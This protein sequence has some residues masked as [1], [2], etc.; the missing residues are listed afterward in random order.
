MA[1]L[2]GLSLLA[3][4]AG[5]A[6]PA[7]KVE[8]GL[9]V[10]VGETVEI[11][12]SSG[13]CWFPTINQFPTGEIIV[14]ISMGPDWGSPEGDITGYCLS[15]DGGH[16]WSP[17]Y[18]MSAT[19]LSAASQNPQKDGAIWDIGGPVEAHPE[20]QSQE[21]CL[22]LTK[23]TRGGMEFTQRRDV[24]LHL[25]QPV[26]MAEPSELFDRHVADPG[27]AKSPS[28]APCGPILEGLNGDWLA[29]LEVTTEKMP[30]STASVLIR[31]SD[32]GKSWREYSTIA[33][34]DPKRFP[35]MAEA[36]ETALVRLA[37]HRL[38]AVFRTA[39]D[40]TKGNRFRNGLYH[41]GLGQA[42]SSD[43]GKTWTPP[44]PMPYEGVM[45]RL[46]RLSNGVLALST[47]R[48]G[49][50]V[51]MF[52]TDGTGEKW[53][54]VTEIFPK[55]S[56]RYTDFVEVAPGKLLVVYDSIPYGWQPIPYSDR[57]AKNTV[58][59]TFVYVQKK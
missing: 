4:R 12:S 10:R 57:E 6:T 31:S 59:G 55:T 21:L 30:N 49:P 24:P 5:A 52:S 42:W 22:T 41:E 27:F 40:P 13:Y 8:D 9:E 58:Y 53:S 1:F 56:T 3:P 32:G 50:V 14:G 44:T 11:S 33:A 23:F 46:R 45:P 17:R 37:D 39:A 36:T 47:G 29:L 48:P 16:T 28:A 51:V 34:P 43:D 7:E 20:G 2:V 38:Y 15:R 54:H 25:A 26:H 18:P 35:W 19:N